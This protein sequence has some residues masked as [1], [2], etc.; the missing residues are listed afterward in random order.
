MKLYSIA[1][2]E[3]CLRNMEIG[4]KNKYEEM[5]RLENVIQRFEKDIKERKAQIERAK[6]EGKEIF[7][8]EKYNKKRI[9]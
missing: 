4:L 6:K 9:K 8:P 7:D 2:H 5:E 3:D 1:W